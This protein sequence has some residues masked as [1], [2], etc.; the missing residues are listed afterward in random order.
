M[1]RLPFGRG[2][3]LEAPNAY[4]S[5]MQFYELRKLI[6][7]LLS[8]VA[9]LTTDLAAVAAEVASGIID[10][11]VTMAKLADLA[12]LSVI[13][14]AANSSGVPAA[15]TGVDGQALRVSGTALGFGTIATAGIAD[16]AVTYAKIQNVSATDKLLGRSTA[17]AGDVEE[18]TLTAAGRALIDDADAS[19]QRTTLGLGT[20]ATQ[21]GTF[22]GTSSGTNTGDQTI[23]LTGDVT[24]SG[25]GSFAATIAAN[26]VTLA[27]LAT[28]AALTVLA[29]ATNG[30]AVPTAVAAASDG[31]VFRRSGTALGFGT[32]VTAGI[33][34]AAVTYAKIQDVAGLSVMGRSA[35]SSG[36]PAD[37]TGTDGQA[38]RVS[39][40]ALGFGTVATA[41][42]ANSAVTYAKIQNVGANTVMGRATNASGVPADIDANVD[43]DVLRLS[44]TTLGF[45]A[46]ATAGITD[47]AV[48]LAKQ[49]N[50]AGLSVP[51]RSA[52]TTGVMAA[53]TGTDGQVLRVSGTA[54]GFGT[55]VA[56][57]IAAAAVTYAKIQD[58]AGLSVMG[59]ASNSSGVGADITGTDGQVLRVSGTALGFGTV[60]TAG[61]ADASI[62][63]AKI[64]NVGANTVMGRASNSS[65]VPADIDAGTD[66]TVLRQ[67]GTTLGFGAIATAGITDNA[68]TLA[69]LATQAALTVLAN[70]T[71]GTAVPTAL[72]AGTDGHILRRSG[73]ALAF[74]KILTNFITGTA[75]NDAATAGDIGEQ[76]LSEVSSVGSWSNNAVK[77]VTSLSLTAGD[78]DVEGAVTFTAAT[79]TGTSGIVTTVSLSTGAEDLNTGQD[80]RF[81]TPTVPSTTFGVT[82]PTGTR[83]ISLASTTT[84]YLTG[85]IPFSTGT[86]AAN[87]W[88]RA[89]RIR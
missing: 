60:A 68:V 12:G 6:S 11:S 87:G 44:G 28:Q 71:N 24:G 17:G 49:A 22:S 42:I 51:G 1:T 76:S 3:Q 64:Q 38:L 85:R 58:I 14:R 35:N 36:V 26:A 73:T 80:G 72:A 39:G 56:A 13:G 18:I 83:R 43:G 81:D 62:T 9:G 29:N 40:T 16:D 57:G 31:D 4:Q 15:I 32:I 46:I 23:M 86:P 75:T 10:G 8:S 54:L 50:L 37:I 65:G 45:G 52:N 34:A 7:G 53:I 5:Q 77:N 61:H 69:K 47:S 89:R 84:V 20:L 2:S 55:I 70:A 59:R 19:A 79:L 67:S 74:G 21:N 33:A 25:T 30:V 82:G 41:G 78:W 88:L 63:Y 48:T 27:K 66:G